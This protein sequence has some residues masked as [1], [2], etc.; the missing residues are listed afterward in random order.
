MKKAILFCVVLFT[1]LLLTQISYG[2][3]ASY[4]GFGGGGTAITGYPNESVSTL[5]KSGFGSNTPCGSGGMSGITV[6]TSWSTYSTA[7]PR[8]YMKIT[9]NAGYQLNV[10]GINAGLRRSGTGPSCV[11]FAYSLDN[12]VTWTDDLSCHGP[13]SSGCG[14]TIVSSWGFGALPTGITSTVNG[15]IVAIF[16][17]ASSNSSGTFQVNTF[18]V[19]GNVVSG[20]TAPAAITGTTTVCSGATTTLS[21]MTASGTWS[22]SNSTIASVVAGTGVVTGVAGGT[23][24]MTYATGPGCNATTVVTVNPAPSAITGPLAVCLGSDITLISAPATG[25]WSSASSNVSVVPASGLI[26]GLLAG[27]AIVTYTLPTSCTATTTITVNALPAAIS[28]ASSV[29]EASTTTWS[30]PSGAGTWVSGSANAT[31]GASS[32]IV[33]GITAGTSLITFTLG[34]TTCSI[35]SVVTVNPLPAAI[36]GTAA[37]C[38]GLT[39]AFND[40]TA[41][42]TWGSSAIGTATVDAAGTVTGIVAGNA[43][44]T[45]TLPTG[46]IAIVN[47]TVNPLPQPITG[48]AVV[49]E[50]ATTALSEVSA[51]GTWTSG[52]ANATVNTSGVVTGVTSGSAMIT[53]TLPTGCINTTNVTV[54][55]TPATIAGTLHVC[56][57][58]TT[59]LTETTPSGTWSSSAMANATIDAGG[60][61]SGIVA[62]TSNVS[63]TLATGCYAVAEVTVNKTPAAITGTMIVCQGL[64]TTLSNSLPGGTWSGSAPGI[65]TIDASGIVTG[66]SAGTTSI[67]YTLPP[68]CINVTTVT[69][70]PIPVPIDGVNKVCFG[71]TTNLNDLTPGGAWSSSAP[72]VAPV[73]ATGGVSGSSVGT[74][75]ISYMLSPGC[76]STTV[77]T[78]NPLPAAITG[79]MKVCVSLTTNLSDGGSG[80]WSSSNGNANIDLLTGTASGVTAGTSTI[81][82]TLPTSCIATAVVTVNPLPVPIS[83]PEGVCIGLTATFLDGTAG[84]TWSIS[85]FNATIGAT[86]GV[87]TGVNAGVAVISY[88]LP[89]GCLRAVPITVAAPPAPISGPTS[90][91]AGYFT[92]SLSDATPGGT[93]SCGSPNAFVNPATGLVTAVNAG[94]IVISYT[95]NYGC[96]ITRAMTVN[97]LPYAIAGVPNVCVGGPTLTLLDLG[98]GTWSSS[99]S[100]ATIGLTTGVVT[101]VAYG[102]TTITYTLP[103]TGCY[104]LRIVSVNAQPAPVTGAGALCMG[105]TTTM[106]DATADGIWSH[107]NSSSSVA[108]I[109]GMVTGLAGGVDTIFYTLPTGCFSAKTV[110]V[111]ALPVVYNVTGSGTY[112]EGAAGLHVGMSGSEPGITYQLYNGTTPTGITAGGTGTVYDF[113]VKPIGVYSVYALNTG[114]SCAGA[115]SGLAVINST[116]VVNPTVSMSSTAGGGSVCQGMPVT[117]T[118][119]PYGGGAVPVFQWFKNGFPVGVFSVNYTYVPLDGDVVKVKLI[120]NAVCAVPDSAI[121]VT[122]VAV[123]AHVMPIV[124]ITENPGTTVC[125]GTAVTFTANTLNG[126]TAPQ[127]YWMKNG[128]PVST[129][130]IYSYVPANGDNIQ[131]GMVSNAQCR[132]QDSAVISSVN[133][134]AVTSS[135]P[136]VSISADPGTYV[137]QGDVV[138]FTAGASGGTTTYS[139]QWWVNGIEVVGA[140]SSTFKAGG[141]SEGDS[142]K[143]TVTNGDI[144][145][146]ASASHVV[147]HLSVGVGL[148]SGDNFNLSVVPNPNKGNFFIKGSVALADQS[149]SIEIVDMMGQMVYK[150]NVASVNGKIEEPI[151][152]NNTLSNGMYILSLRSGTENKVIHF[153]IER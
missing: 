8:V 148:V 57:G 28:G 111:N 79:T 102:T 118:A 115:M 18:N 75:I 16:P 49:C 22:S 153:V 100:N 129:A 80:T 25:T 144:C 85:N 108:A 116:P 66:V 152:L 68:G 6:N 37:V 7:G 19:L 61:V 56:E 123:A 65:A 120:S 12:G 76:M 10:T 130:S 43:D 51:G 54:N 24:I 93:W 60:L 70:N 141:F 55:L 40:A 117:L 59:A 86:S 82:Y 45:Y 32:G 1:T 146:F 136:L 3:L 71:L 145:G 140:T 96:K 151:A 135:A 81:T 9:P 38:A 72:G 73:T 125:A 83:G 133:M 134:S 127:Y 34:T 84:G 21:D 13:S 94:P 20:C 107:R 26:S 150:G 128:V 23:A 99:N 62:G 58:L 74:A 2:Q 39:T 105:A 41:S 90:M 126:G 110:V 36:T 109:S 95:V 122:T 113:G 138:T 48:T 77:V 139:Y 52:A 31:I 143:C 119:A 47:V 5:M 149:L 67:T 69:V 78:V 98:G 91:C 121:A 114:T 87:A 14:S 50:G 63:Y 147:M 101:A 104:T 97:P 124:A 30:D 29:C 46:C 33:S 11:R 142:V 17:Y 4:T 35:T 132:V 15:I 131:C 137:H 44:I 106:A 112:C 92:A 88:S 103:S 89:T 53:Y 27:T 64:T 42:G